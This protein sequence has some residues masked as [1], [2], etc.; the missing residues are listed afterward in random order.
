L[1][2]LTI[3]VDE[4]TTR[5]LEVG[6]VVSLSGAM[7]T[8]RDAAHKYMIETFIE[9]TPA[10]E[11]AALHEIL[12]GHLERGVVYHCGPVVAREKDGWRFVAAGPTTSIREEPYEGRVIAHFGLAGVIGKGGMGAGT[13][14]ACR[15]HGCVYLHAVG[16]AATFIAD[17]VKEVLAVHREDLGTPEAFW[18]IRVEGFPAVVTMDAKGNSLHDGIRDASTAVFRQVLGLSS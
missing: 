9:G 11:D 1:R 14:A 18:V 17:S 8:A 6:E 3:P 7:V 15:E 16:G 2:E 4:A 13:L 10:G 12:K 5:A